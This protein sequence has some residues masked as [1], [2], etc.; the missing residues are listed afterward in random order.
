M[1]IARIFV[2]SAAVMVSILGCGETDTEEE[3]KSSVCEAPYQPFDTANYQNQILRVGAYTEIVGIRK[4]DDFKA[5]DFERIE[6]LYQTAA[7]LQEKVQG[8]E[9]DH[10]YASTVA[11]GALLDQEI[12][13]AIAAG[14]SN[15][16]IA[17]QGQVVDKTLQRFF[18]LSVFHEMM[19]SQNTDNTADGIEKGWDEAFGYFGLNNDGDT[20]TGIAATIQKRDIEFGFTLMSD[21]FNG[22]LDGRCLVAEGNYGD[23]VAVIERVDLALLRGFALS[24]VHEMDEYEENPL[25][26]GWEGL[27]YWNIVAEYVNTQDTGVHDTIQAEFDRGPESIDPDV[28]RAAIVGAFGFDL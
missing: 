22:L 24:V 20:P 13:E 6:E 18:Y 11:I 8:R 21:V 7:S 27:L 14:T 4:S 16:E 3:A 26:K 5:S 12:T 15:D 28:V 23:L 19:K 25:I 1:K 2:A 10:D 9:D 17:V